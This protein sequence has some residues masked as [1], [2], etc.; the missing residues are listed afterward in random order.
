MKITIKQKNSALTII[1]SRRGVGKVELGLQMV[2]GG[3]ARIPT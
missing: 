2:G 3:A 1:F